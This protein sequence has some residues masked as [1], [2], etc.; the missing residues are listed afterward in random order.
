MAIILAKQSGV[1]IPGRTATSSDVDYVNGN[2][3]LVVMANARCIMVGSE[4][5][6]DSLEGIELAPG[7]IAHT[8]GWTAAWELDVDGETWVTLI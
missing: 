2:G 1:N 8:A 5:D 7:S 4:S 6:L 3:D